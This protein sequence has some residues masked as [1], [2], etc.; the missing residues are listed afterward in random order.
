VAKGHPR[1]FGAIAAELKHQA[2]HLDE[3]AESMR[4]TGVR[5]GVTDESLSRAIFTYHERA[6]AIREGHRI[7]AALA[8]VENTIRAIFDKL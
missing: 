6:S 2:D 1:T 5:L 8:P 3:C 7:I 4:T